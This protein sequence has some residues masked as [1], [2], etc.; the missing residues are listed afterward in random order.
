MI[1][2]LES[3]V[4]IVR[5]R[6]MMMWSRRQLAESHWRLRT[7]YFG[8]E[9]ALW[10]T[11]DFFHSKLGS[12][13]R[14]IFSANNTATVHQQIMC[15]RN[16]GGRTN[17]KARGGGASDLRLGVGGAVLKLLLGDGEGRGN[18]HGRCGCGCGPSTKVRGNA[19]VGEQFVPLHV[20]ED[21]DQ[22]KSNSAHRV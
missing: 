18:N 9:I 20:S 3:I 12:P 13:E 19:E 22:I 4:K 8:G 2:K 1:S 16:S 10:R 15:H 21:N 7:G 5:V 17:I 11:V 14:E 6:W